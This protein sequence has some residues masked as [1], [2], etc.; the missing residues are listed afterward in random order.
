MG[1]ALCLYTYTHKAVPI[2]YG[3]IYTHTHTSLYISE[4]IAPY[5]E[6]WDITALLLALTSLNPDSFKHAK[7]TPSRIIMEK[8]PIK[9]RAVF[10]YL[11]SKRNADAFCWVTQSLSGGRIY[12]LV[13]I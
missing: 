9:N 12:I 3:C 10:I 7:A 11:E 4:P 13:R 8:K 1:T 5:G 2:F 6:G